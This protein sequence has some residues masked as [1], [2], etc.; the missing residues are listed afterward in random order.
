M[1][2]LHEALNRLTTEKYALGQI[3][4]SEMTDEE[5]KEKED[6][7]NQRRGLVYKAIAALEAAGREDL[8]YK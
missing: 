4:V 6:Y 7:I 8:T 2:N 1:E 3:P 5:Y